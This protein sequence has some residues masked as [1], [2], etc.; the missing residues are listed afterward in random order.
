M[1]AIAWLERL[2]E[3]G[4]DGERARRALQVWLAPG[5][6]HSL[7]ACAGLAA[8]A[9]AVH[10]RGIRDR[11][12]TALAVGLQPTGLTRGEL[13]AGLLV[14]TQASIVRTALLRYASS[15]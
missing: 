7:E 13:A 2:P 12:L 3:L 9:R 14:L 1:E 15:R 4:P 10:W 6:G 11:A 5:E 8:T